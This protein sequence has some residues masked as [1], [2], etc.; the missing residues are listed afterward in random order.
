MT[1]PESAPRV[2]S[3]GLHSFSISQLETIARDL[4]LYEGPPL[5]QLSPLVQERLQLILRQAIHRADGNPQNSHIEC[6]YNTKTE[7]SSK[8]RI[9][10][11]SILYQY[12]WDL[13]EADKWPLQ[14]KYSDCCATVEIQFKT[15]SGF[16]CG[17]NHSNCAT[18]D[19][20]VALRTEFDQNV[21]L[22]NEG[23]YLSY[24]LIRATRTLT[25]SL[26]EGTGR[27]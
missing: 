9:P 6:T 8:P 11:E 5:A 24:E 17:R 1:Q 7:S 4:N 25:V 10:S 27:S 20:P 21:F 22:E 23:T 16:P 15:R 2:A 26:M 19:W 12:E 14:Y 3:A 13:P 18:L